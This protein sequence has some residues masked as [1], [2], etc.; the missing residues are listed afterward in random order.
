MKKY[1]ICVTKS[2]WASCSTREGGQ[3]ATSSSDGNNAIINQ[4]ILTVGTHYFIGRS[5]WSSSECFKLKVLVRG[6]DCG[7]GSIC[8]GKGIC[9]ANSS[10]VTRNEGYTQMHVWT[11][12]NL[13]VEYSCGCCRGYSGKH[14]E[15]RDACVREPCL[16]AGICVDIVEGHDGDT[17]QCLCPYVKYYLV[18][19]FK[20]RV[21]FKIFHT[22]L[23]EERGGGFRGK[24]CE[25]L[26]SL[27]DSNPCQN[28][29]L[30]EGNHTY[31]LCRCASGW[32]GT[33]CLEKLD[34]IYS[35]EEHRYDI[36][37][38]YEEEFRDEVA[39]GCANGPCVHGVCVETTA[40]DFRCFCQPVFATIKTIN[41]IITT[42][43]FGGERCEMEYDE[44]YSNPCPNGGTCVDQIGAYQC[45]CGPGFTG[46]NCLTKL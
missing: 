13:K 2:E 35:T 24:L 22:L 28:G 4:D 41:C 8:S 18:Y 6:I 12:T 40:Q 36:A 14:C 32:T 15:E 46:P 31:Y 26:S 19:C 9:F 38:D 44:C 16:N 37:D 20:I 17:F 27:C 10:M 7:E 3:V 39:G 29:G 5:S 23:Q 33:H 21:F 45:L 30:C 42:E 43:G 25:T 34:T 1:Y 11:S